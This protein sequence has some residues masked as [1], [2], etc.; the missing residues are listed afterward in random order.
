VQTQ[1]QE[2]QD[3]TESLQEQV[4]KV[5][6]RAKGA[7]THIAQTHA[8]CVGLLSDKVAVQVEDSIKEKTTQALTKA[9]ELK[10]KFQM[11]TKEIEAAQKY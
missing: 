9:T 5:L 6:A 11:I 7:R 3:Q 10:E 4:A 2:H 8:E 1:K